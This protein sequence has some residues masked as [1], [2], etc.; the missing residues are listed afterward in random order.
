MSTND[1]NCNTNNSS[2]DLSTLQ[3]SSN[4]CNC[5]RVARKCD[6]ECVA[7]VPLFEYP[8]I[9]EQDGYELVS[10]TD[11]EELKRKKERRTQVLEQV[12]KHSW[13]YGR[14]PTSFIEVIFS[15]FIRTKKENIIII[16][17]Y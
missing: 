5:F 15:H 16:Q 2:S 14:P 11:D 4:G 7:D 1:N 12:W 3:R 9:Q 13:H 6:D 17:V 8:E 10:D